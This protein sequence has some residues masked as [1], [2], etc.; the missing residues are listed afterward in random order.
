MRHTP[1]TPVSRASAT[2]YSTSRVPIR[3]PR[4]AGSAETCSINRSPSACPSHNQAAR[5]GRSGEVVGASTTWIFPSPMAAE[6][7]SSPGGSSS[8]MASRPMSLNG[9]PA[10]RSSAWIS[11]TS[12]VVAR[13]I[14]GPEDPGTAD[15]VMPDRVPRP[16]HRQRGRPRTAA[17][18]ARMGDSQ[19]SDPPEHQKAVPWGSSGSPVTYTWDTGSCPT[20]AD[21][22]TPRSMTG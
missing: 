5:R 18:A 14:S 8:A 22:T 11:P 21:S 16:R 2:A 4:K 7:S 9:A 12:V 15:V 1:G 10:R 19:T 17:V 6:R 13:R 3:W 20:C